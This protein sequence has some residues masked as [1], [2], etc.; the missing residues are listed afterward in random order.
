MSRTDLSRKLLSRS[1]LKKKID[2]ERQVGRRIVFTNGCFDLL[3]V[4]HVRYLQAARQ[5]GDVLVV[6]VNADAMVRDLK[7]PGRPILPLDQ[8]LRIL[9][10]L[11]A[12]NYAVPFEEPTP[13]AVLRELRPDVLVKGGD[14]DVDGV[15]GREVV[16]GYGGEICVVP[17]AEGL[18][19]TQTVARIQGGGSATAGGQ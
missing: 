18:S 14:Y 9:A 4:G 8:R 19:T 5:K 16:W 2:R 13:H 12:V 3:H 6:A 7:G 15:V 10:A 17:G 1:N 11:S